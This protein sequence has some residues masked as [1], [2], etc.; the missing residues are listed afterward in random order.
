MTNRCRMLATGD[1]TGN[2]GNVREQVGSNFVGNLAKALE[3]DDPAVSTCPRNNRL[4][5]HL[6]R[7]GQHLIVVDIP[8]LSVDT[9]K[10]R[11]EES[12]GKIDVLAVCQV[13]TFGEVQPQNLVVRVQQREEGS[14]VRACARVWLD[15]GMFGTK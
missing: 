10:V 4:W 9:I 7:L 15:V 3:V 14:Q 8:G 2:V 5:P 1:Q 13:T 12:A 11:L 6:F